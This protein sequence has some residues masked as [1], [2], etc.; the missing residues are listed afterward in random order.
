MICLRVVSFFFL[1]LF[2]ECVEEAVGV[3]DAAEGGEVVVF[4]EVVLCVVVVLA[5]ELYDVVV[6]L[7][8]LWGYFGLVFDEHGKVFLYAGCLVHEVFTVKRKGEGVF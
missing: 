1:L 8:C 5:G 6:L 4:V 7:V 2:E 3:V